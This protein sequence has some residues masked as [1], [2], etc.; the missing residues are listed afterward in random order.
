MS[1]WAY[2]TNPHTATG[3]TLFSLSY[4]IEAVIPAE[5]EVPSQRRR[6]CP[7]DTELNEELLIHQLVMIEEQREKA[8]IRVQKYQQAATLY[9][10]SNVRNRAFSIGDLVLRKVFDGTKEPGAGKLGTKWE[11]PYKVWEPKFALSISI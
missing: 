1:Y 9:N 8:A 2:R 4:G 6:I 7:E 5:I 10:Y 3:E 11:G